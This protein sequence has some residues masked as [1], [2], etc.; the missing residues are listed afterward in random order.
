MFNCEVSQSQDYADEH[1][2]CQLEAR[3]FFPLQ[4]Q[5]LEAELDF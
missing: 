2:E 3:F 1:M 4:T 5:L